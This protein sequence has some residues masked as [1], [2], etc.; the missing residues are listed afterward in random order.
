VG[1]RKE[2]FLIGSDGLAV[3]AF[4]EIVLRR[5]SRGSERFSSPRII[6]AVLEAESRVGPSGDRAAAAA[7]E[8]CA[9]HKL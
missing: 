9:D 4:S 7:P 6:P 5:N 2:K 1:R 8:A 3:A